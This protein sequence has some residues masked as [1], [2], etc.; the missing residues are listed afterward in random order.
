MKQKGAYAVLALCTSYKMSYNCCKDGL[1]DT[2]HYTLLARLVILII[3]SGGKWQITSFVVR[4]LSLS[5]HLPMWMFTCGHLVFE[6]ERLELIIIGQAA[7]VTI[8]PSSTPSQY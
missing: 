5:Y 1:N 4:Y 2:R 6:T 8:P 7:Q 3:E